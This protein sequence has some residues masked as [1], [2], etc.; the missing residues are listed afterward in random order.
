VLRLNKNI[1]VV[2]RVIYNL[3]QAFYS[4]KVG[5]LYQKQNGSYN[6]DAS[7]FSKIKLPF[8]KIICLLTV[9]RYTFGAL[10]TPVRMC[11]VSV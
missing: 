5:Y 4:E 8:S 2:P 11:P 7:Y 3:S 9:L 1:M 6:F 10:Q